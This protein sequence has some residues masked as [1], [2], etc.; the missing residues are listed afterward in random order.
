MK[1]K[2]DWTSQV[3]KAAIWS[4]VHPSSC[5]ALP[6]S[7]FDPE[8]FSPVVSQATVPN[9]TTG[10]KQTQ[11]AD[12]E[13]FFQSSDGATVRQQTHATSNRGQRR[14]PSPPDGGKIQTT[15]TPHPD[16]V[17][18]GPLITDEMFSKWTPELLNLPSRPVRSTRNPNP[19]YVDSIECSFSPA[20]WSASNA[21]IE[22]LN[23]S[24]NIRPWNYVQLSLFY[25]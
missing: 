13:S 5:W 9:P 7:Y 14:L 19:V 8:S 3:P 2:F 17:K 24:I 6:R 1:R 4:W 21:E 25:T 11:P 20:A 10:S 18:K 16:Y 22:A 12:A 15:K 23:N